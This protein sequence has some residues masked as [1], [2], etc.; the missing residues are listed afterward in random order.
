VPK[1]WVVLEDNDY[2]VLKITSTTGESDVQ[3]ISVLYD[4][5]ELESRVNT[6]E[7]KITPS[8]IV[9]TVRQSTAYQS[10]LGEKVP[11]NSVIS[12]INQSAE[13]LQINANRVKIG[14][15]TTFQ[16]GEIYTWQKYVGKTWNQ[17]ISSL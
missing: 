11:K 5:T 16:Q 10:D 4:V 3:T 14:A 9:Q 7:Q 8:A 6:A 15:G 13:E 1:G 12:E 17:V 2:V